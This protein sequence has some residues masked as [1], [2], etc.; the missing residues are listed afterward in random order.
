VVK[1]GSGPYN[2]PIPLRL[3]DPSG[4][5]LLAPTAI[6]SFTAP[7]GTDPEMYYVDTG[8]QF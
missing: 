4:K 6:S 1:Q 3:T 7:T 5:Q 8:V 2:L